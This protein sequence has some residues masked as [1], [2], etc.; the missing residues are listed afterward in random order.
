L[1]EPNGRPN[2]GDGHLLVAELLDVLADPVGNLPLLDPG[3]E[4]VGDL[5]ALHP[6][7]PGHVGL[8]EKL[9]RAETE[10]ATGPHNRVKPVVLIFPTLR[11]VAFLPK[12]SN[13]LD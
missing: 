11:Q 10:L 8:V 2:L 3:V 1:A 4:G 9:F 13:S 12:E 7:L 6:P 5:L